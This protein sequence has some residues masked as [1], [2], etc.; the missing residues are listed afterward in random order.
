MEI[1]GPH[2][3]T[4]YPEVIDNDDH[5]GTYTVRYTPVYQGR[6][7]LLITATEE[8]P[9][10]KTKHRKARIQ[11][12]DPIFV[13]CIASE[14]LARFDPPPVVCAMKDSR[15]AVS[16]DDARLCVLKEAGLVWISSLQ[17]ELRF[18]LNAKRVSTL[19][20]NVRRRL[21]PCRPCST[22]GRDCV[23]CA[24]RRRFPP[25]S[26]TR[27]WKQEFFQT[28]DAVAAGVARPWETASSASPSRGSQPPSSWLPGIGLATRGPWAETCLRWRCTPGG[29]CL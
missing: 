13:N 10:V 19:L 29:L 11:H 4:I 27:L 1:A 8:N 9:T 18:G 20:I 24:R 5:S 7:E 2:G 25:P 22:G 16:V 21:P 12:G 15:H 3:K 23:S 14:T 26:R 28:R 6:H 17:L